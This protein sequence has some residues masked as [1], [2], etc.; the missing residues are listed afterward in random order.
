MDSAIASLGIGAALIAGIAGSAHCF[1]MCGAMAGA[2]GMRARTLSSSPSAAVGHTS[3]YH[4]GRL[5][6]YEIGRA[7]CR[8]RV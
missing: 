6:G 4:L 7:S 5:L 1:G 3:L 2:L 8:E